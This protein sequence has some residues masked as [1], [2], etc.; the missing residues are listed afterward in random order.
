MEFEVIF[1][2]EHTY[3]YTVE[4]EKQSQVLSLFMQQKLLDKLGKSFKASIT[5]GKKTIKYTEKEVSQYF[6][7]ETLPDA[8]LWEVNAGELC[9]I[10]FED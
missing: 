3:Q 4:P 7:K 2:H 8:V 6:Y 5:N 10:E 9:G 1:N